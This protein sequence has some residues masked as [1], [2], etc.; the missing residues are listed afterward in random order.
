MEGKRARTSVIKGVSMI[1][2]PAIPYPGGVPHPFTLNDLRVHNT[3][4]EVPSSSSLSALTLS[5]LVMA[6]VAI[7]AFVWLD[8]L[9]LFTPTEATPPAPALV[10]SAAPARPVERL[11]IIAPLAPVP[12]T[13]SVE[14]PIAAAPVVRV[15]QVPVPVL[16]PRAASIKP[17]SRGVPMDKANTMVPQASPKEETSPPPAL[18]TKPEEQTT[19]PPLSIKPEEKADAPIV[20]KAGDDTKSAPKPAATSDQAPVTE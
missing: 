14:V 7:V 11:E 17:E 15:P 8:P 18:L 19:P 10:P 12:A 20:P 5:G 13:K 2:N 4:A 16:R 1:A 3:T 6:V 9:R